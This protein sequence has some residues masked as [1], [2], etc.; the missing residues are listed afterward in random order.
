MRLELCSLKTT[1]L[2]SFESESYS[3]SFITFG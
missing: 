1:E 3:L 2:K